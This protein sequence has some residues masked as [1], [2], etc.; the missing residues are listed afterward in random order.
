[1]KTIIVFKSI[2]TSAADSL[3]RNNIHWLM[4]PV[5]DSGTVSDLA[6]L[7]PPPPKKGILGHCHSVL[8]CQ[9]NASGA[10]RFAAVAYWMI[11]GMS[12]IV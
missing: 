8:K 5:S 10:Q 6:N 12:T 11:S 7:E 1:M 4:S 2:H 3:A 9:G